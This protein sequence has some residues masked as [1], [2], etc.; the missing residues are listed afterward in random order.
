L[1]L[2]LEKG[3]GHKYLRRIPTGNPQR[4]YRYLYSAAHAVVAGGPTPAIGEKVRVTDAGQ[5]GHYEVTKVHK[6]GRVTIKH[7]ETGTTRKVKVGQLRDML[8]GEHTEAIQA[9]HEKARD[10]HEQ[11]EK[12]G[13][14]KQKKQA[15]AAL[16]KL[17]IKPRAEQRRADEDTL[18]AQHTKADALPKSRGALFKELLEA[19][20]VDDHDFARADAAYIRWKQKQGPKPPP[21]K[22]G[23][24]DA[25]AGDAK[26]TGKSGKLKA[27]KFSGLFEA[28]VEA[29]KGAKTYADIEAKIL[30]KL[31]DT[32]GFE[33]AR[34]PDHVFDRR[35][36]EHAEREDVAS[37]YEKPKAHAASDAAEPEYGGDTSFDFGANVGEKFAASER[38]V[39]LDLRK[40]E[41]GAQM[42]GHRYIRR[43][44]RPGGGYDYE[45]AETSHSKED[46]RG[47]PAGSKIEVTYN[48]H[49]MTATKHGPGDDWKLDGGGDI[50]AGWFVGKPHT[51]TLPGGTEHKEPMKAPADSPPVSAGKPAPPLV[52][53]AHKVQQGLFS[54]SAFEKKPAPKEPSL[55]DDKRQ[56]G[57]F[58]APPAPAPSPAKESAPEPAQAAEALKPSRASTEFR[59]E[60]EAVRAKHRAKLAALETAVAPKATE[61]AAAKEA[62]KTIADDP[63]LSEGQ[64]LL[65]PKGSATFGSDKTLATALLETTSKQREWAH[66]RHIWGSAKDKRD[67][68]ALIE[69]GRLGELSHEAAATLINRASLMPSFD[70]DDARTRGVSPGAAHMIQAMTALVA[71]KPADT[72]PETIDA[73]ARGIRIVAASLQNAKTRK[74]VEGVILDLRRMVSTGKEL[75]RYATKEEAQAAAIA[76]GVHASVNSEYMDSKTTYVVE[77][78]NPATKE[79]ILALGQRFAVQTGLG[80]YRRDRFY[81]AGPY[82]TTW[83]GMGYGKVFADASN[84][85]KEADAKGEDGWAHVGATKAADS[86]AR[87]GKAKET[88]IPPWRRTVPERPE[89]V[90]PKVEIKH[91][92]RDRFGSAFGVAVQRGESISDKDLEHHLRHAE[93][94]FHDMADVLGIDPK[95]MSF[96]GRLGVAF[97]ARGHGGALAHYE[98]LTKAINLTRNAGAGSL[99]HEWGHFLDNVLHETQSSRAGAKEPYISEGT[100]G[101]PPDLAAAVKD[102]YDAMHKHPDPVVARAAWKATK[103]ANAKRLEAAKAAIT[104]TTGEARSKAIDEHNAIAEEHNAHVRTNWDAS[105]FSR[106]A[107]GRDSGKSK[108][109]WSSSKEMWARAFESYVFDKLKEQGRFNSYLVHGV[110]GRPGAPYPDG[111]ERERVNV[112]FDKFFSLLRAG[113]HLEKALRFLESRPLSG[114]P[115]LVLDLKKAG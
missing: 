29:S 30:P 41:K 33:N 74:D 62:A 82:G 3:A 86:A 97:G 112:A 73:Y 111:D 4:P 40:G 101:L 32:P 100:T 54:P 24:L 63:V 78:K 61:D 25:F 65:T 94:A 88:R 103:D 51:L 58:V 60:F 59:A 20:G 46:L 6:T 26:A 39:W 34:L 85:A 38:G 19:A 84:L 67:A 11:A 43:T 5:E 27:K 68:M 70:S 47:A 37:K 76:H 13:S 42:P 45:Y 21:W 108:R 72:K 110:T 95:H 104:G 87:A 77:D 71:P 10:V 102:V 80:S 7:D 8:A 114:G 9:A 113:K 18:Q 105:E 23:E 83:G 79:A 17:Q 50:A 35:V 106:D 115:R 48:G 12:T 57:L 91:G 49:P 99:A 16:D 53:T 31:R 107:Q 90:K 14:D 64:Q 75:G 66:G 92:D 93:M 69:Q 98:P 109:Y 28:F 96:K 56:Q 55:S 22:G 2:D 36:Q 89:V 81:A 1:A 52:L 44:P 15:R